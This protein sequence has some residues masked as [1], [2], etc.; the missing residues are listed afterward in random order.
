[1]AF[2]GLSPQTI[3]QY[4]HKPAAK[5]PDGVTPDFIN[6]PSLETPLIVV[7]VLFVAISSFFV[8]MRLYT[9]HFVSGKL[10][11]DDCKQ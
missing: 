6:P 8:A 7:V 2:R 10:W 9:R 1:M 4:M 3:E 5:A 11:W